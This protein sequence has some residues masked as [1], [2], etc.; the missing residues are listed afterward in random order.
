MNQLVVATQNQGKLTEI[1]ELLVDTRM[2]ICSLADIEQPIEI[3][4]DADSFA[5]NAIKKAAA[6][7][8]VTGRPAL[9]DDSGLE[10]DILDGRPGVR[11]ARYGGDGLADAERCQRLLTELFMVPEERR[12]A[13]FRCA[14]AFLEPQTEP[15]LFYGT[16]DGRIAL[17]ACGDQGFGYDP[18]FIP[19]GYEQTLAELG[20]PVKNGISHR[21]R[22]LAAFAR[23][24][25]AR[26]GVG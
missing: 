8:A 13:R 15:R 1:R 11:S 23:W 18:I 3:V 16:L 5:G 10:V 20:P 6:V 19:E 25:G 2:E 26:A 4:E 21:A 24:L 14:M 12:A 9:A 17:T 22:A 7:V